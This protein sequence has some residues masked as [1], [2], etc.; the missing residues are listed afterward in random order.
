MS[1]PIEKSEFERITSELFN[2]AYYAEIIKPPIIPSFFI[3]LKDAWQVLRGYYIAVYLIKK[4][5]IP[6]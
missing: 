5:I 3:R 2:E 4:S 1:S 6:R